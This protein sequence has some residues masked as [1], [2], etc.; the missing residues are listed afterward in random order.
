MDHKENLSGVFAPITTPF[1]ADGGVDYDGLKRNMERYAKSPL[2]GYL[3]LGSNGENKSM[4]T[5]EKLRVLEIIVQNKGAHQVVMTGCIAESTF[6]TVSI[7]KQA[8]AIGTD[9]VTLLSP[10]YFKKQMTDAALLK[11]F[12][13]VADSVSKPCLAYCAPQFTGGITLSNSLVKQL[14]A[15]ANIVGMKDSSTGNI[16][17]YLMAVPKDFCVMAGS[18]NFFLSAL[19]GGASGG[20]I[21][22]ANAFPDTT[23]KLYDLFK[24]GEYEAC[25]ALNREILTLN[26]AVSGKGGVAAVKYAME[27]AGFAGGYPR[28]PLLPLEEADKASIQRALSEKGLI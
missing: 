27:L 18:A 4:L 9:Y 28:L 6:E 26:G 10:N 25:F 16:D 8:C 5:E 3:A 23:V 24:A 2:K 11:Y 13:D 17:G 21:S 1:F 19:I 15:H 14:A 12:T 7:A 22:L 20:V